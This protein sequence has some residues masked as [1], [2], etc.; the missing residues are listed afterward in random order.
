MDFVSC[1][2]IIE[3]GVEVCTIAVCAGDS[4]I[5]E[6]VVVGSVVDMYTII[7]TYDNVVCEDVEVRTGFEVCTIAACAGDGVVGEG[8]IG[9]GVDICTITICYNVVVGKI[10]VGAGVDGC[11][12]TICCDVVVYEDVVWTGWN[13]DPIFVIACKIVAWNI[14]IICTSI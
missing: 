6:E 1:E 2:S 10:V 14:I 9:A 7:V 13:W 12:G 4:I 11:T 5:D 3:A 8:V